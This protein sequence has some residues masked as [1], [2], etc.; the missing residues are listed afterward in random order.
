MQSVSYKT[1][2]AEK[3]SDSREWLLIDAEHKIL[4]R[5]CSEIA[6]LL[7]GKHQPY[8]TP[9]IDCGAK[10]VLINARHIQLTKDKMKKKV[11]IRHTGYPGGQRK[12]TAEQVMVKSPEKII[13]HAVKGMLPKNKLARH[14]LKN[15]YIFSEETH[16]KKAQNPKKIQI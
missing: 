6:K 10:V 1:R 7:R 5:L 16:N 8:Y 4:G 13:S 12:M 2:Y 9:H 3:S 15:L 11:Y 14:Q